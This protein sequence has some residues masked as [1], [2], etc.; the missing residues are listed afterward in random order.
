MVTV[1]EKLKL[2]SKIV[3]DKVE[4]K[5]KSELSEYANKHENL[6]NDKTGEFEKQA[7]VMLEKGMNEIDREKVLII[8]KAKMNEKKLILKTKNNLL[9]E[10]LISLAEQLKT[11]VDTDS[12]KKLFI[13]EIY[14]ASS[15]LK[16]SS[17][18][19]IELTAKDIERFK[20]EIKKAFKN[21]SLSLK[22]NDDLIGGFFAIDVK[23]DVKV[24]F[25]LMNKIDMSREYAGEQLFN[26][27]Q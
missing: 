22:E 5:N 13:D 16:D 26:L 23:N 27:L 12:Y 9:N 10:L 11:F 21:S 4:K 20:D 7:N 2:F 6:I 8:S 25:S 15:V 17:E 14:K 1:E 24:D 19:I 3:F 18:I